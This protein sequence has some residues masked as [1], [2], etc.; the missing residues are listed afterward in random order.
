MD[1]AKRDEIVR[2]LREAVGKTAGAGLAGSALR[3]LVDQVDPSFHPLHYGAT[4]LRGFIEQHAPDL[5]I[6]GKTGMDPVYGFAAWPDRAATQPPVLPADEAADL[7]RIWVSPRSPYELLVNRTTGEVRASRSGTG[8]SAPALLVVRAAPD[9]THRAIVADFIEELREAGSPSHAPLR[10]LFEQAGTSW[11]RAWLMAMKTAPA[12]LR[13]EWHRYRRARLVTRLC[14]ELERAGLPSEIR[15]AALRRITSGDSLPRAQ[16]AEPQPLV[17][18]LPS[19]VQPRDESLR[20]LA[21]AI[22]ARMNDDDISRLL[23]PL[24]L[25]REALGGRSRRG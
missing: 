6:I 3:R 22:V 11:V 12:E 10:D 4:N 19:S 1:A 15:E 18:A 9:T 20:D 24:G 23:V 16:P 17:S 25:A 8:Q 21:L 2:E 14:E 5:R 13:A 7:W